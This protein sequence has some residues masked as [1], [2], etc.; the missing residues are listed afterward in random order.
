MF[1]WCRLRQDWSKE[2]EV[3]SADMNDC[4]DRWDG[5]NWAEKIPVDSEWKKVRRQRGGHEKVVC[6]QT[7][8]I[9]SIR[10][11]SAIPSN[12]SEYRHRRNCMACAENGLILDGRVIRGQTVWIV[13]RVKQIQQMDESEAVGVIVTNVQ[14]I[15]KRMWD[16]MGYDKKLEIQAMDEIAA[17]GKIVW[18]V[19]RVR[20]RDSEWQCVCRWNCLVCVG[21]DGLLVLYGR[22][23]WGCRVRLMSRVRRPVNG[24][25]WN[26]TACA[27][28]ESWVKEYKSLLLD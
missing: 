8:G 16:G 18:D 6:E 7:Y 27:E 26:W 11:G 9:P 12:E 28:N 5:K 15:R 24:S 23:V 4:G 25:S 14:R 1:G 19:R 21:N 10:R 3:E 17:A 20:R 13:S 2:V 22:A